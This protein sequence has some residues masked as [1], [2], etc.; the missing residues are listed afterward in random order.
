MLFN[1]GQSIGAPFCVHEKKMSAELFT[2][3][4]FTISF[5]SVLFENGNNGAGL[6]SWLTPGFP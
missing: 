1:T 4:Y 6:T 2:K 3:H 5:Q